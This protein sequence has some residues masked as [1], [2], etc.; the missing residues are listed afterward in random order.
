MPI[1][2]KFKNVTPHHDAKRLLPV[3]LLIDRVIGQILFPPFSNSFLK[4]VD[5]HLSLRLKVHL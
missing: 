1:V 3:A 5:L 2:Y 4:L